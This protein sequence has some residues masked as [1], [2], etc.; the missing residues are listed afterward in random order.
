MTET[1]PE[2]QPGRAVDPY[3]AYN[4]K[5]EIQGV[6]QAHFTRVEG[7][8]VKIPR[9]LYRE[10][11]LNSAVRAI[12]GQA[13][14]MPVVRLSYGMTDSTEL[15]DWL[16]DALEGSVVRRN[17]SLAMLND[18]GNAEV[19][20]WNLLDAWPCEWN[21]ALLDAMGQE[22][23]IECLGLAFDRLERFRASP[24]VA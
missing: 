23:A 18:A 13:L 12:P 6:V 17:V 16:W 9:I 20:R 8:G 11:G 10:A 14:D 19:R 21:G 2:A 4:F 3:R 15:V 22:L 24:A 7:L 5:L 1:A